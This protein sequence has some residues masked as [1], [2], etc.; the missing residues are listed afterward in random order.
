M[1]PLSQNVVT[2]LIWGIESPDETWRS[3]ARTRLDRLTKPLGSLGRLEDLA[4]QL[5]AIRREDLSLPL[6]KAAYIFAADHGITAEGVSA[7]P[8][9]VTHQ[10]VL[11]FLAGGAA[12]N[13]L[14]RLHGVTLHVVDVG[15]DAE[16]NNIE[17]LVH[18]K[19]SN[20]TNNM[21]REA[22]MTDEELSRALRVGAQL[23]IE[24]AAAGQTILAVGEMGIGNT[25]SASAITCAITGS[26][27]T[28]AT[29]RGTGLDTA[30][31][32][33]KIA[34]VEAILKK[35][36]A[37]HSSR[38]PLEV[39]RCVGGLEIAAMTGMILAA[40]RNRIAIVADGFISTAAAAVAVTIEPKVGGYLIAGH[41]SE[42]PGHR[43]LLDHLKLTPILSLDMRLGEGSGAVLAMPILESAIGI[44][45]QMATFA[46]AG[47]S[48]ASR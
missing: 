26:A 5:M 15:V 19:I 33:R 22:A 38:S 20:G 14:A 28:L 32:A 30:A 11:N 12:V 47:V 39:L 29:G 25:T 46:S 2:E 31:H 40:A 10:M 16:F 13:V 6:N 43:L 42:E 23:A 9:A 27:E 3:R 45:S 35:H 24:A 37:N 17:G 48:E 8:S 4:A 34:I 36:F 21:L 18:H 7:Y 41:R 1:T 44:Y